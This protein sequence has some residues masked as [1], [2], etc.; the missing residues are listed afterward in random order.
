M[1]AIVTKYLGPTN[2]KGSRIKASCV[3]G[4]IIVSRDQRLTAEQNH[5]MAAGALVAKLGWVPELGRYAG[6]WF[7]AG[8]PNGDMVHVAGNDDESFTVNKTK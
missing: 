3:A 2:T 1:Q 8:L 4:S 7:S 6:R 5:Q